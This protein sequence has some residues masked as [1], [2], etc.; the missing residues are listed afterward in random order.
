[1]SPEIIQG[2]LVDS[3]C[4][5]WSIGVIIYKFFAE[6]APFIGEYPEDTLLKIQEEE[7]QFPEGFPETAM[8]LCIKLLTKDPKLRLGNGAPG[9]KNDMK[10]L[11]SHP[12]FD[13]VN[14]ETLYH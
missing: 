12:F 14:F 2:G 8:D 10:A 13:G 3:G 5:L 6:F 9:S 4:D 11:K 7:V 1:M